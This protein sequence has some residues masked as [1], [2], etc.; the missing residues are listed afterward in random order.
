MFSFDPADQPS[1]ALL[2]CVEDRLL[3]AI[4]PHLEDDNQAFDKWFLGP[5]NSLIHQLAK[6]KRSPGGELPEEDVRKVLLELGW[7][8]Y[9][10]AANCIHAQMRTFQNAIPEPLSPREALL[11]E[12]MH[13]PQAYLG[14]FPL[15]L[16]APRFGFIKGLLWEIWER[17][18]DRDLLPVFY[19]LLDFYGEMARRRREADRRI[20]RRPEGRFEERAHVPAASSQQFQDVAAA[21]R[22]LENIDCGCPRREWWAELQGSPGASIQILHRCIAC[23]FQK[24]TRLSWAKFARIARE[25]I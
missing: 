13:L 7:Q 16:L 4:Y 10:F 3:T 11:F 5:K 23:P 14:N 17:L 24:V 9:Q 2:E 20:K 21:V 25:N 15:I 1:P 6:Q 8:S 19:R 18:P 22:E 12:H